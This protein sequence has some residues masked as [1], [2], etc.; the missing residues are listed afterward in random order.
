MIPLRVRR[1]GAVKLTEAQGQGRVCD[2][3]TEREA[4]ATEPVGVGGRCGSYRGGEGG[5]HFE[6]S[7][8]VCIGYSP[9]LY[10][11]LRGFYYLN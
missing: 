11:Q 2:R 10:A 3:L 9:K 7:S 1:R 4:R 5:K 8:Y 6:L